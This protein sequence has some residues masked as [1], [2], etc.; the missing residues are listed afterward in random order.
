[1]NAVF[2]PGY[3]DWWLD[4]NLLFTQYILYSL[5]TCTCTMY[6]LSER[7]LDSTLHLQCSAVYPV[8]T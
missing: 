2:C 6:V 8:Y 5:Y 7:W 1:M 4:S 3:L